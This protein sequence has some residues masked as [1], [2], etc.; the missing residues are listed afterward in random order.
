V[1]ITIVLVKV[2]KLLNTAEEIVS[3]YTKTKQFFGI[4]ER[5][6]QAFTEKIFSFFK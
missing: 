3:L 5:I 6:P 2:I 1:L 4:Y